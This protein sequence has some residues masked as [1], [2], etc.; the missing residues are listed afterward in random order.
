MVRLSS[1]LGNDHRLHLTA[2]SLI[3]LLHVSDEKGT[4]WG[5][6]N[7]WEWPHT[8]GTKGLDNENE[9]QLA[10][11]SKVTLDFVLFVKSQGC[12]RLSPGSN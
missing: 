11:N 12:Y 3:L 1:L 5:K 6:K 10:Q 7:L 8:D 2:L 9:I 4:T